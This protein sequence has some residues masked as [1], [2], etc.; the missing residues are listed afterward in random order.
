MTKLT[1]WTSDA[2]VLGIA[3]GAHSGIDFIF[4]IGQRPPRICL[5]GGRFVVE[6]RLVIN[7][8]PMDLDDEMQTERARLGA[9]EAITC[10][11]EWHVEQMAHAKVSTDLLDR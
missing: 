10:L 5:C 1:R 6:R 2:K 8:A 7:V 3:D 11:L 4:W 9:E